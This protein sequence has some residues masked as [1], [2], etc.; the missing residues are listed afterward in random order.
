MAKKDNS[1]LLVLGLGAVAVGYYLMKKGSGQEEPPT[2]DCTNGQV[3]STVCPNG[4]SVVDYRCTDGKWG[5]TGNTCSNIPSVPNV[6]VDITAPSQNDV[7]STLFPHQCTAKIINYDN[8]PRTVY[9]G[10][11][12]LSDEASTWAYEDYDVLTVKLPA[13]GVV[14]VG[15]W[16]DALSYWGIVNHKIVVS[17]WNVYPVGGCEGQSVPCS[18]LGTDEVHFKMTVTGF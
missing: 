15:W 6:G 7:W 13:L 16:F 14:Q 9:V 4:S 17:A 18:R 1:G 2:G 8:V 12:V 10:M 5:A 11:T 3:R